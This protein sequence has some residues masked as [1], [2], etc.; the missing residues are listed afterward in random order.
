MP[1]DEEEDENLVFDVKDENI[2]VI[3]MQ[4][5]SSSSERPEK[6]I[7]ND[8]TKA[9]QEDGLLAPPVK[10]LYQSLGIISERNEESEM[11]R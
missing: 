3:E 1:I 5:D 10:D 11:T 2:R 7:I 4:S 9:N 8:I 6:Q